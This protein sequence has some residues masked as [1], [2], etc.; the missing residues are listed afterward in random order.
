MLMEACRYLLERFGVDQELSAGAIEKKV[1]PERI[2]RYRGD[3]G[4]FSIKSYTLGDRKYMRVIVESGVIMEVLSVE[5][6]KRGK[7]GVPRVKNS[8]KIPFKWRDLIRGLAENGRGGGD[9]SDC[10]K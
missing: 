5:G 4:R 7:F 3:Y 9:I 8:K 6:P 1:E 10:F 2:A